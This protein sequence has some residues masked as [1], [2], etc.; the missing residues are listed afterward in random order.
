[1]NF[2]KTTAAA[3]IVFAM[4][5]L[6]SAQTAKMTPQ[7]FATMAASSDMMELES[8]KLAQ[9]KSQTASVKEFAD[10]MIKDHT[11]ASKNLKAAATEDG[12]TVPAEMLPKHA[13]QV[14]M[15]NS[16]SGADFDA[17]YLKAQLAAHQEALKL[18]TSYA[19]NGKGATQAHA[20]KTAPIIQTHL[21]HAEMMAKSK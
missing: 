15:L 20:E 12:V 8:S 16:Q 21:E 11:T 9:Q 5:P 13:E 1:M 3:A 10:M 6:A 4:T 18:M 17:A 2:F 7:E 19:E 14:Q